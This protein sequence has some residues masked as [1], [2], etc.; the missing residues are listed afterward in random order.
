MQLRV[1]SQKTQAIFLQLISAVSHLQIV[2]QVAHLDIKPENIIV[3]TSQAEDTLTIKLVDFDAAILEPAHFFSR[4][5]GTFPFA[6][7]EIFLERKYWPY[8]ADIWSTGIVMLEVLCRTQ[9]LERALQL[10]RGNNATTSQQRHETRHRMMRKIRHYFSQPESVACLLRENV[11]VEV[12][13]MACKK[14]SA[15][16]DGMINVESDRRLRAEE[17]RET[18]EQLF[19]AEDSC[20]YL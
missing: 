6:A 8:A 20:A 2:A 3:G 16:L 9:V 19:G 15:L 11:R 4:L 1:S 14:L 10:D 18:S 5:V 13:R 12:R 7:P 17:V